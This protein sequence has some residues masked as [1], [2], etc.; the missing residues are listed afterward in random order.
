MI[1]LGQMGGNIVAAIDASTGTHQSSMACNPDNVA[2]LAKE[3][4]TP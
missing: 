2:Q 1:G 4:A 3:G